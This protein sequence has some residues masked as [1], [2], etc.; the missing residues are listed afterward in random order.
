MRIVA[1][2]AVAAA[3]GGTK[4]E[5][6][7][8]AD[9]P[10]APPA[11]PPAA[12]PAP[13]APPADPPAEPVAVDTSNGSCRVIG[14]GAM[15][16]D[17]TSGNAPNALVVWQWHTPEK[18]AQLGAAGDGFA[19][20]CLGKDI[21]LNILSAKGHGAYGPRTYTVGGK[22]AGVRIMGQIGEVKGRKDASIMRSSGTLTI[23]AFDEQHIAGTLDVTVSTLPDRGEITLAATFDLN[24]THHGAC[25]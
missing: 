15:T 4:D 8:T 17:Q 9:P 22:G 20:N 6:P 14:R 5:P 1:V 19:I 23:T 21:R 16:F 10:A 13:V 7:A 24:C 12:P 11:D 2:V 3:C 18:R 25:K